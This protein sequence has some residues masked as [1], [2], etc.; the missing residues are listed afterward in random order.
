MASSTVLL[1]PELDVKTYVL[2]H[3]SYKFQKV[4]P[5]NG[6]VPVPVPFTSTEERIYPLPIDVMNMSECFFT[7]TYTPNQGGGP[8]CVSAMAAGR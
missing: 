7:G 2:D 3:P 4:Q 1:A 8:P 6:T 5:Q